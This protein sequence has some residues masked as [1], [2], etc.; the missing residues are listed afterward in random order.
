[1]PKQ[2]PQKKY[3]LSLKKTIFIGGLPHTF[4]KTA[5]YDVFRQFGPIKTVNI[6]LSKTTQKMKG[7]CFLCFKE[8]KSWERAIEAREVHLQGKIISIRPALTTKEAESTKI[9]SNERRIY[10]R[11]VPPQMTEVELRQLFGRFGDIEEVRLVTNSETS[12][13]TG[14]AYITMATAE[15]FQRAIENSS[16]LFL[17][18][19]IKAIKSDPQILPQKKVKKETRDSGL[20]STVDHTIRTE[21]PQAKNTKI[22][23]LTNKQNTGNRNFNPDYPS[24]T[25]KKN[26]KRMM[27]YDIP[28]SSYHK[29][30]QLAN[31]SHTIG[32]QSVPTNPFETSISHKKSS[33]DRNLH[34]SGEQSQ[35]KLFAKKLKKPTILKA[36]LNI[37][38]LTTPWG[39]L[40]LRTLAKRGGKIAYKKGDRFRF[41]LQYEQ[42]LRN[43]EEYH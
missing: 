40:V 3:K 13:P 18:H 1:M 28:P 30:P 7:F 15:G 12:R 26:C 2:R 32:Q 43:Q 20:D 6:P 41:N 10:S 4:D 14:A 42:Q 16:S 33:E 5:I 27:L 35:G 17:E 37:V 31:A 19:G 8:S 25:F 23:P 21:T 34:F 11:G 36:N 38:P 9:S 39:A 22:S 29:Q 24:T